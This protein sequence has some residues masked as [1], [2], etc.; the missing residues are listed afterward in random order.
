MHRDVCIVCYAL[1]E[2]GMKIGIKNLYLLLPRYKSRHFYDE[3]LSLK[4]LN[5]VNLLSDKF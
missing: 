2:L 4:L 3:L 1:W 5:S